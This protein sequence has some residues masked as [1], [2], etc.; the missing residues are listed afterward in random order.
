MASQ[1]AISEALLWLIVVFLL[2]QHVP[3]IFLALWIAEF[4]VISAVLRG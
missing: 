2:L 4:D 1:I 3:V